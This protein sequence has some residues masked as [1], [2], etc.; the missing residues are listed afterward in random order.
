[1]K[2]AINTTITISL[3]IYAAINMLRL[4][5]D[6]TTTIDQYEFIFL[7]AAFFLVLTTLLLIEL[8]Q[9][10]RNSTHIIQQKQHV[11]SVLHEYKK[12]FE[13]IFDHTSVGVII[14]QL[15]GKIEHA[16][17]N[18]KMML[19]YTE[20]DLLKMNFFHLVE[21]QQADHIQEG[22]KYLIEDKQDM[23]QL[24]QKCCKRNREMIWVMTTLSLI[25][26]EQNNPLYYIAQIQNITEKK[27][28]EERLRYMAYHDPLTSL[29]NRNKLEQFVE[30]LIA[31]A[32]RHKQSFA[33]LFLDIDRFKNINDTIGHEA[34]DV[35]LQIIA[36]RLRNTVRSTDMVARL[37]G[38]EFVILVSDV[39]QAESAAV[40]AQKILRSIMEVVVIKGQELYV[41]TS[42]GISL[43]PHDGQ[44]MQALMKNAD[45]AL[46]RSKDQGRNNYQF[47][48]T[49]MTSRAIQKMALQTALG[50]AL[51]RNEFSLHYQPKMEIRSRRITGIEALLRW[52]NKQYSSI[53]AN[54]IIALAQ[55]TGLIIP[56]SEWILQTAC[57]QL[58]VW[59]DMGLNTL[60]IAI[61]CSARL[62]KQ[63]TFVDDILKTVTEAGLKPHSLEIEVTE[64]VIMDEPENTLRV[65]FALKDLG[66]KVAI[67]NFGTGYWSLNN[68]KKLEVDKIKIDRSFIRQVPVDEASAAITSAIIA[69]V[70]K[71]GIVS[72]AEGVET[73]QQ[74]DFLS[75]QGCQEIQGYYL[76][77]PIPEDLM[78]HFLRHPI[79]DAEA[80]GKNGIRL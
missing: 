57:R 66:F 2:W 29:A 8:K 61:N 21:D 49:E 19:G 39:K 25:R 46:Y 30:H 76:T 36:E 62:F 55:E 24:E 74:L 6:S 1:M 23:Y 28:A 50:Q 79:P 52:E 53:S 14:F 13:A 18:V 43:Y 22:I 54:E 40:I 80:I 63:A 35:L 12:R 48:T 59:H 42:I 56:V 68:L 71:L 32:S 20:D 44:T 58:K 17:K 5:S 31:T 26:N 4:F 38:D 33:I 37:G 45:L 10:Y 41:T 65:L 60:T 67:D 75:A 7:G 51:V 77:R 70:N 69:M 34:G 15:D 47:Y 27:Q 72:L 64:Q 78:T 11:V 16:N 9:V 3:I 73:K